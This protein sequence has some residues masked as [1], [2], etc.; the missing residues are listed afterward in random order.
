M[1]W[2]SRERQF[3]AVL[4]VGP[5]QTWRLSLLIKMA[6]LMGGHAAEALAVRQSLIFQT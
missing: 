2:A 6:A 1:K 4:V 5:G 3:T